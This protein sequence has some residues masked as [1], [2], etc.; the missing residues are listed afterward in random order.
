M[1]N[2]NRRAYLPA[3]YPDEPGV[4][5]KVG[6]LAWVEEDDVSAVLSWHMRGD[7]DVVVTETMD[8]V[9]RRATVMPLSC[10]Q[11]GRLYFV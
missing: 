5:G 11:A 10:H 7:I 3:P 4:L 1:D 6:H 2:K 8:K 9:S